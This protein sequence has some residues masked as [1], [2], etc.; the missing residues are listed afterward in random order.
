[1][2]VKICGI[3][4]AQDA[5]LASEM[6]ADLIGFVF[7][8][9]KRQISPQEA[10]QFATKIDGKTKKVGVFVNES[11]DRML[12]IAEEVGL[13]FIQLHGREDADLAKQLPYPIIKAFSIDDALKMDL[14]AYPCAYVLIDT[15]GGGTGKSFDWT[16]L[17]HLSL[18]QERLL[19][20]GGLHA[21]NV[22]E[23]IQ[24]AAPCGV[25]VSSGVETNGQ[26]DPQKIAQFITASKNSIRKDR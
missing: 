24:I 11:V 13:D 7:A 5:Q 21:E 19:L 9:S 20:A 10:K 23:A 12:A 18:P 16:K 1:M 6:G 14:T 17:Q 4:T 8:P 3:M 15:P 26:K 22:Q 2:K 25:D